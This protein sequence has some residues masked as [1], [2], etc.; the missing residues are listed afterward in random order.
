MATVISSLALVPSLM[1]ADVVPTNVVVATANV[2]QYCDVVA[3]NNLNFVSVAPGTTSIDQ[4]TIVSM[5]NGNTPVTPIVS[6][7]DWTTIG[8]VNS[9]SVGQTAWGLTSATTPLTGLPGAGI[10]ANID[11]TTTQT[12]HFKLTVPTGTPADNYSQI[13]TFTVSC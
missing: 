3:S 7:T 10:G 12:V 8:G 6:G 11:H 13:I 5:P 1:A 9:M 2:P 4:S